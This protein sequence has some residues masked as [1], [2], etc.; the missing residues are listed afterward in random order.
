MK[1]LAA[2]ANVVFLCI[3][4]AANLVFC[5]FCVLGMHYLDLKLV[6]GEMLRATC[7]WVSVTFRVDL[8]T[9]RRMEKFEDVAAACSKEAQD[10]QVQRLR[11]TKGLLNSFQ[12]LRRKAAAE[13][14]LR[15]I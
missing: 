4:E 8:R 7:L 1:G 10:I 6:F 11:E 15:Q 5:G 12:E 13:K 2:V 9:L 14:M 3:A